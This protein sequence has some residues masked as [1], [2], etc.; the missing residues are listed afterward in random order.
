MDREPLLERIE[1]LNQSLTEISKRLGR[2]ESL[3]LPFYFSSDSSDE[4]AQITSLLRLANDA[5]RRLVR[6]ATQPDILEAYLELASAWAPRSVLYLN[7]NG[8]LVPWRASGLELDDLARVK[9]DDKGSLLARCVSEQAVIY[10]EDQKVKD[11]GWVDETTLPRAAV[12]I[13]LC[14]DDLVPV[15]LYADSDQNFSP[16][17]LEFIALLT[18]LVLKNHAL[19][20]GHIQGGGEDTKASP[21]PLEAQDEDECDEKSAQSEGDDAAPKEEV[22]ADEDVEETST[23][24]E[25][26]AEESEKEELIEVATAEQAENGAG[27]ERGAEKD[28]QMLREEALRFA[29]LLVFEIKLYNSEMVEEGRGS[30]DIYD[31]LRHDIDRSRDMY[32]SRA[33]PTVL[34]KEDCFDAEIVRILA[35]GERELLGSEYPG[36]RLD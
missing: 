29:R 31:R 34:S 2:L 32:E 15:V 13:P 25:V 20:Q 9:V 18:T 21:S 26:R 35:S 1:T 36:P 23:A 8:T 30:A 28:F 24:A 3:A 5:I 7:R 6:G 19:Q 14:F 22:G 33:H 16:V 4:P 27:G 11:F 17:G 12:G 10:A